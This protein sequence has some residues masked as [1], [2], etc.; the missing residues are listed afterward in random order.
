MVRTKMVG[1]VRRDD[2]F[3]SVWLATDAVSVVTKDC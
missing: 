2:V 1:S 3:S